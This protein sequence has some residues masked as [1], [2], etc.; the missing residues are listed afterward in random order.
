M[1]ALQEILCV[2]KEKKPKN[3]QKNLMSWKVSYKQL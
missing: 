3:A 2:F 1:M